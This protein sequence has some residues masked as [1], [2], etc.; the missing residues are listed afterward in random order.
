MTSS[1]PPRAPGP[2]RRGLAALAVVALLA[3]PAAGLTACSGGS[4]S[5]SD[6]GGSSSVETVDRPGPGSGAAAGSASD[7]VRAAVPAAESGRGSGPTLTPRREISRGDV[8]L[9]AADVATARSDVRALAH[10]YGGSVTTDRTESDDAGHPVSAHLVLRIPSRRFD[11]AMQ[12]LRG[13]GELARAQATTRDVTTRVIDTRVRLQAQRRSVH[14]VTTLLDRAR[15]LRDIVLI[16]SELSRRQA[17]L[18]SL[19]QQS[20][21]LADQTSR[22]TIDVEV[23]RLPHPVAR[24]HEDRTGFLA[25]LSGGW[26]ALAA[27]AVAL[28][29]VLGAVLPFAFVLLVLGLVTLPLVRAARR[30]RRPPLEAG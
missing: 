1:T 24:H 21:Y 22:S 25:G 5:S 27:T 7:S 18:D 19:E 3:G 14:R 29:T 15:N 6:A 17:A 20:A 12:A 13:V 11:A 28:A 2:R 30:R 10:R 16:E 26:H 4:G 23:S 8:A 9:R